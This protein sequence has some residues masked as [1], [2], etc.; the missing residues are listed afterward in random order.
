MGQRVDAVAYLRFSI[1][2]MMA[3]VALVALDC[4]AIRVS[5]SSLAAENAV[6]VVLPMQ[7]VLAIGLLLMLRRRR[8]TEKPLPFLVGFEVV[9]WTCLLICVAV[10]V[11]APESVDRHLTYILT[12]LV[13]AIGFQQFSTPDLI[14]RY[15]IAMTYLSAPQ[16]AVALVAGWISQRWW[17]QTHPETV[18]RNE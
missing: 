14:C 11:R 9:G 17:K 15:S 10:C 7:S 5:H 13:D 6:F 8:R 2:E 16:L 18:P 4:L 1:A 3:I 12:P